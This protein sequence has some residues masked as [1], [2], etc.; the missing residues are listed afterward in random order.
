M[1]IEITKEMALIIAAIAFVLQESKQ[2]KAFEVVK[3]FL[4][5]ISLALGVACGFLLGGDTV[6]CLMQGVVMGMVPIAGYEVLKA[7]VH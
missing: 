6:T 4:A 3:P 5:L 2:I 1:D 7:K